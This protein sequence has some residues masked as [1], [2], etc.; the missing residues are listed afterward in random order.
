MELGAWSLD[1]WGL[2]SRR[3]TRGA[4]DFHPVMSVRYVPPGECIEERFVKATLFRALTS[5]SGDRLTEPG[6][7]LAKKG[8]GLKRQGGEGNEA[9]VKLGDYLNKGKLTTQNQE[10]ALPK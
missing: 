9:Q 6:R 4:A 7:K 1:G 10:T 8:C 2:R 3:H 5:L